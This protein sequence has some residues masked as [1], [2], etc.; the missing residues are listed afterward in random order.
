M[1]RICVAALLLTTIC[2]VR[3]IA[4]TESRA[5]VLKSLE[6]KR[7]ELAK[8][9]SQFLAP[10]VEDRTTYAEFLTQPD[11]GLIRLLPREKFDSTPEKLSPLTIRGGGAYYSFV[12]L[13]HEYGYG[14]DIE[15][16]NGNLSVGFAGADYGML[17]KLDG[18]RL[19]DVSTE[20]PG[21]TF[22]AKY[23]AV[24][25]EPDARL[26]Q[27]RFGRGTI[28]DGVSYKGR[29]PVEVGATYLLRS[30]DFDRSDILVALRIVRQDTDGSVIIAWKLLQKYPVP[31]LARAN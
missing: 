24:G 21:V 12:R 22:L 1:K 7:A 6:T 14:S 3:V 28:I 26:E 9:E 18:V 27:T 30:I 20:I 19:E 25:N 10:S 17:I 31:K 4:Q 15:L 8:L 13:T 23:N 2:T 5:E 11:T 16:Y 29:V